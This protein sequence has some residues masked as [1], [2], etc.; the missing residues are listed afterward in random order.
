MTK[1][2]YI[3]F[4]AL[5]VA[6]VGFFVKLAIETVKQEDGNREI[7]EQN[8]EHYVEKELDL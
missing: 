3:I 2:G 4:L 7:R 5:I 1:L 8:M 6:A